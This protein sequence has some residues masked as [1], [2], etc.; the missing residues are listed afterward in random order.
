MRNSKASREKTGNDVVL[1]CRMK[2][3]GFGEMTEDY[4]KVLNKS[5][6]LLLSVAQIMKN[7]SS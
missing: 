1:F 5:I 2:D 3:D 6:K 4:W 7:G